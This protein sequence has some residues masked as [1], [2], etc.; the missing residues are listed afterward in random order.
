MTPEPLGGECAGRIVAIGDSVGDLVVGDHVVGIAEGGGATFAT[1]AT[2]SSSLVR[3][4]PDGIGF[5]E[6]ATLPFA[7]HDRR[8]RAEH[9]R[10]NSSA[11]RRS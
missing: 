2:T 5:A 1:H 9:A 7:V 3:K 11:A 4:I 8:P 6:A 10:W